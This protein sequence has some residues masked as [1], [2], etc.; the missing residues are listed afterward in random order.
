VCFSP[1]ADVVVGAIVV[2]VGVDAVRHVTAPRQI[3]IATLP[4]LL[5]AHQLTEAFVWWGLYGDVSE[6]VE[7]IATWIYLLVALAVVPFYIPLAVGFVERSAARR[8]VIGVF[9]VAGL[10]VS[11]ALGSAM[12][13]GPIHAAIQG[14]HISYELDGLHAGGEWTALY[15]V[16]TCGALLACSSRDIAAIG[17]LNFVAVPVLAW[18]TMTGFVSLWCFWAAIVSVLIARHLRRPERAPTPTRS[19]F[20][21]IG[22]RS[23]RV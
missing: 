11:V 8:R 14:H 12:F 20:V 16:A 22:P 5:G 3:P 4:L 1:Q 15:V 7:R 9:A 18:L 19:D 6:S 21:R 13:R 10:V 17:A 2:G 23:T